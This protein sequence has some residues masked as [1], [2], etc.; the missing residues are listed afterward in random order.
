MMDS[1]RA[2]PAVGRIDGIKKDVQRAKEVGYDPK[3]I[4]VAWSHDFLNKKYASRV[5]NE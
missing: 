1:T 2:P 5:S 3:G 4:G